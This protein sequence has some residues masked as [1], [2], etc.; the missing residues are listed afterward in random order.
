MK[1]IIFV[2]CLALLAAA[3]CKKETPAPEAKEGI[4]MTISAV[5]D[6][7]TRTTYSHDSLS[8]G[9]LTVNWEATEK[10]TVVSIGDTGITAVDE[11][12]SSGEAGRFS[13]DF[14]GQ[15]TGNQGDTII[16]LYPSVSDSPDL[17]SELR[18]GSRAITINSFAPVIR[19]EQLTNWIRTNPAAPNLKN[20]DLMIGEVTLTPLGN[21]GYQSAS[22]T[23]KRQITIFDFVFKN[24]QERLSVWNEFTDNHYS[25]M[26]V[27]VINASDELNAGVLISQATLS[28]QKNT[29]TGELE[30]V[31]Y[32]YPSFN[33]N[34]HRGDSARYYVPVLAEQT[35][36][37]QDLKLVITFDTF[38]KT[39]DNPSGV[40]STD[41]DPIAASIGRFVFQ[42][43][44][45]YTIDDSSMPE[46]PGYN[47]L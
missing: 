14:G 1:K 27:K 35:V 26:Y 43:G 45:Y 6:A 36:P 47:K 13:A 24:I 15:W 20:C 17:Y 19:G 39:I 37:D 7:P 22:V 30:P 12:T 42:R 28:A 11:F 33:I 21:T 25:K 38:Y 23:F 46:L 8:T 40:V 34:T 9:S 44:K 41:R 5:I 29:Y 32:E 10:I 16:C 31:A 18:V 4:P 3:A 2:L